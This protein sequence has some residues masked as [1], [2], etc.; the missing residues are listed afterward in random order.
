LGLNANPVVHGRVDDAFLTDAL[1]GTYHGAFFTQDT[2]TVLHGRLP[3][4]D[5][6]DEIALTPGIA[7]LFGVGLG[8][9]VTYQYLHHRLIGCDEVG[10]TVPG[11][12][13][14]SWVQ[15]TPSKR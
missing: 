2:M 11:S 3:R 13:S 12:S 8:G 15:E 7:R 14:Y 1:D 10:I 6:T 9:T 4:L 5:T